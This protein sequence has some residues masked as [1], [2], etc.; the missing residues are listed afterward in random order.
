VI[1]V[2]EDAKTARYELGDAWTRPHIALEAA[3]ARSAQKKHL[4][5]LALSLRHFRRS[6]GDRARRE[7]GRTL[8]PVC[9]VPTSDAARIYSKQPGDL[10]WGPP[11]LEKPDC[12]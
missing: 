9:G 12:A 4:Q 8:D 1:A 3:R 7:T 10:H 2:I 11:F 6:A 5:P